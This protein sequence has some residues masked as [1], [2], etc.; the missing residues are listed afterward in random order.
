MT[1]KEFIDKIK[2]QIVDEGK[3]NFDLLLQSI[4]DTVRKSCAEYYK[5]ADIVYLENVYRQIL[6]API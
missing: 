5:G 2:K 1:D 6:S 4:I 3:G